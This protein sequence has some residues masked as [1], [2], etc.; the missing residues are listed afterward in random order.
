MRL[1]N[2]VWAI[3]NLFGLLSYTTCRLDIASKC[4]NHTPQEC[5]EHYVNF[6]LHGPNASQLCGNI[7]ESLPIRDHSSPF[8]PISPERPLPLEPVEQ[9]LLGYMIMR[10]D[11]DRD[12]DNN[13][14][15]LLTRLNVKQNCDDL[16]NGN[17]M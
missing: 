7:S 1:S 2:T 5:S 15:S 6:Y 12:Y 9:Q 14:E 10:D 8:K 16:E 17:R 3:G 13:A 4:P 11:F